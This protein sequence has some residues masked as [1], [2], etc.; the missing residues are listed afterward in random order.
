MYSEDAGYTPPSALVAPSAV[1]MSMRTLPRPLFTRVEIV[2]SVV[3][4]Q[5]IDLCCI[6]ATKVLPASTATDLTS[7]A[8]SPL[9]TARYFVR[10]F[11]EDPRPVT[12]MLRPFQSAGEWI[13]SATSVR[14]RTTSPG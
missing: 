5:S 1:R 7:D 11:V 4:P 13:W 6:A 14:Q 12:P 3:M 2:G 10:K 8:A 9:R